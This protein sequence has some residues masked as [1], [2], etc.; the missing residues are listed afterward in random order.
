MCDQLTDGVVIVNAAGTIEYANRP[1]LSRSGFSLEEVMGRP[2]GQFFA[3]GDAHAKP[4]H[5]NPF[6]ALQDGNYKGHS[7]NRRKRGTFYIVDCDLV[8][9]HFTAGQNASHCAVIQHDVSEL[10]RLREVADKQANLIADIS[11]R[12]PGL[13]FQLHKR[14]D[15]GFQLSYA[16]DALASFFDTDFISVESDLSPVFATIHPEDRYKLLFSLFRSARKLNRWN[17][18][19][20]VQLPLETEVLWYS[21]D[22]RADLSHD[23]S[24]VWNGYLTNSTARKKAQLE[25]QR[26]ASLLARQNEVLTCARKA[27]D[28]A[29]R[30]KSQFLGNMSHEIRTPMNAILGAID[31]LREEL[32]SE[33]AEHLI[34]IVKSS[35]A[36]LISVLDNLLSYAKVQSSAHDPGHEE[37]SLVEL[38]TAVAKDFTSI[39]EHKNISFQLEL[40]PR[41]DR[42][43]VGDPNLIRQ[44]AVALLSN[45]F[46]FTNQGQVKLSLDMLKMDG[47]FCEFELK[48]CDTGIGIPQTHKDLVFEPFTQVDFSDTRQYGGLGLGLAMVRQISETMGGQVSLK[49]AEG[50]GTEVTF[51]FKVEKFSYLRTAPVTKEVGV[52]GHSA[53]LLGTEQKPL[54][55]VK[56]KLPILVVDDDAMSQLVAKSLLARQGYEVVTASNGAE[57]IKRM[58]SQRYGLVLMDCQMPVM[59]GLEATTKIREGHAGNAAKSTPI[60]ALTALATETDADNCKFAGMN[61]YLTK[62][63]SAENLRKV[64][65]ELIVS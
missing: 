2:Y 42:K 61:A 1:A 60:V 65:R 4:G 7:T 40:S 11:G 47:K 63:V 48:V 31:L 29:E 57:A 16:S 64:V 27:A 12:V 21:L 9:L 37:F 24:V 5:V 6:E 41:A 39:A 53:P 54:A 52:P 30:A 34:G 43:L 55:P 23:G 49:S 44:V 14:N 32:Q 50:N 51:R 26:Q 38:L 18:E 19:F 59:D 25:L 33:R 3:L 35:G 46:K 13:L 58:R 45:S 56:E 36:R 15:S 10:V 20:R 62:P 8:P 22:A 28:S 17:C